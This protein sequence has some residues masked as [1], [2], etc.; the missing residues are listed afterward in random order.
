MLNIITYSDNVL[1]LE[2]EI[3]NEGHTLI[4]T[5]QEISIKKYNNVFGY[6]YKHPNDNKIEILIDNLDILKKVVENV[7]LIINDIRNNTKQIEINDNNLILYFKNINKQLVNSIRR[8]LLSEIE[9]V[10]FHNIEIICNSTFMPD[11]VWKQ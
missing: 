5:L 9:T 4:T 2:E 6:N 3:K 11:E 10:A 1:K 8:I 7:L